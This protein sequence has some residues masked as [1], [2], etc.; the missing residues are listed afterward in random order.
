MSKKLLLLPALSLL[1]LIVYFI[2][3]PNDILEPKPAE[4]SVA[5][6]T[7]LSEI[8]VDYLRGLDIDSSAESPYFETA[9]QRTVEFF[10]ENL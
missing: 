4:Q 3:K 10:R 2:Y 9:M 7:P 8:S 5:V 6:E 1:F